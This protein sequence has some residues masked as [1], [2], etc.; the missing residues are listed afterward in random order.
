MEMTENIIEKIKALPQ[1]MQEEVLQYI[2]QLL[3]Q[4]T[5][6]R[7]EEPPQ[8]EYGKFKGKISL[9]VDFDEPLDY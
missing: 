6:G 5:E 1:E 3:S 7:V 8:R 2:N 9:R 4:T